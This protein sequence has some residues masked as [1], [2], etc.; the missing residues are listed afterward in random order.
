MATAA[1]RRR[2]GSTG[3]RRPNSHPR[4][5]SMSM[6]TR[7]RTSCWARSV[8]GGGRGGR[9]AELAP[10]K[11][12]HVYEDKGSYKLLDENLLRGNPVIAKLRLPSGTTHFVVVAGKEGKDYLTQ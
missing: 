10:E 5:G 8:R 3:R 6:R 2:G 11:V 7:E 1:T 12:K 4:R 9:A